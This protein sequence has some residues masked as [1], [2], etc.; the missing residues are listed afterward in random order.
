M[1]HAGPAGD[2]DLRRRIRFWPLILQ[3]LYLWA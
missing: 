1:A 2:D 3:A